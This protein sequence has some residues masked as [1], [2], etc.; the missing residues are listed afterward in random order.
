MVPDLW[1]TGKLEG[2]EEK[3]VGGYMGSW[4]GTWSPRTIQGDGGYD[5]DHQDCVAA[6]GQSYSIQGFRKSFWRR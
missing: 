1:W 4:G 2:K 5:R 3:D 6:K